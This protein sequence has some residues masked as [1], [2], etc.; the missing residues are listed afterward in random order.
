MFH[1]DLLRRQLLASFT[2]F[3][4]LCL[5]AMLNAQEEE[6]ANLTAP[7]V[8]VADLAPPSGDPSIISPDARIEEL[9]TGAFSPKGRPWP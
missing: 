2:A 5:P 6:E 4:L 7:G 1:H 9:F 3:A 8:S